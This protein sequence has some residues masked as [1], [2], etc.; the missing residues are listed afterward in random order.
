MKYENYKFSTEYYF[1]AWNWYFKSETII[2]LVNFWILL[3]CLL[4][5]W[6]ILSIVPHLWCLQNF[7]LLQILK[8][9]LV[10]LPLIVLAVWSK[11]C[12]QKLLPKIVDKECWQKNRRKCWQ[13]CWRERTCIWTWWSPRYV[14]FPSWCDPFLERVIMVSDDVPGGIT[15]CSGFSK[16]S[17][18]ILNF[19]FP[20]DSRIC[21]KLTFHRELLEQRIY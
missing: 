21:S 1:C 2:Q 6:R 7:H 15:I 18:M 16:V 20:Q 17:T 10:V 11:K 19:T 3:L 8:S 4:S 5:C 14:G 12:C 13:K 9:L